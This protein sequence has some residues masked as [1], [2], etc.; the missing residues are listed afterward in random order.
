MPTNRLELT[1]DA[2]EY[3]E[4]WESVR[5][6]TLLREFGESLPEE[7]QSGAVGTKL[8]ADKKANIG[9]YGSGDFFEALIIPNP[10]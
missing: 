10:D 8:P 6:Q 9:H 4:Y 2:R 1:M 5:E 7:S 3:D